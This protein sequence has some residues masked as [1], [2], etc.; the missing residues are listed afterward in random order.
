LNDLPIELLQEIGL[1]LDPKSYY[2]L[3]NSFQSQLPLRQRFLPCYFDNPN[4]T[5]LLSRVIKRHELNDVI[6]LTEVGTD[7]IRMLLKVGFWDVLVPFAQKVLEIVPDFYH[8]DT[9]EKLFENI[10]MCMSRPCFQILK[11]QL[12]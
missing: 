9:I 1:Y 10:K 2:R 7:C 11:I 8:Q 4:V 6:K 5:R 12:H 3:R